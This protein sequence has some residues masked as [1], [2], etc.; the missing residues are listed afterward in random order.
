MAFE[1]NNNTNDEMQALD[2]FTVAIDTLRQGRY[3]ESLGGVNPTGASA[4][5]I[6]ERGEEVLV[7]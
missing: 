2:P 5:M 4:M 7:G 3:R 1:N 6:N